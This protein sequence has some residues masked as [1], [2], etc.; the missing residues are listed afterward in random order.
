MIQKKY[1][2]IILRIITIPYLNW[3][4]INLCPLIKYL[5]WFQQRID[6]IYEVPNHIL[7]YTGATGS[8]GFTGFTGYTGSTGFT[9]PTGPSGNA[10]NTGSTG[11]TGPTGFTG[12]TGSTGK[13]G[14]TGIQG[15]TGP[16]GVSLSKTSVSSTQILLQDSSNTTLATLNPASS[17]E[18]GL[19][20]NSTLAKIV[21]GT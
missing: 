4:G 10:T 3:Y 8:T 7:V 6:L 9:G 18:A 16:S 20:T 1:G 11:Y 14:P 19:L 2:K 21:N 13:T 12:H 5:D 15:P 17:S